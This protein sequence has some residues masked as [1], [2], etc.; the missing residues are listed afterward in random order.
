MR[1]ISIFTWSLCRDF[2][3]R[4]KALEIKQIMANHGVGD[5][6][7]LVSEMGYWSDETIMGSSQ[8]RQA[9]YLVHFMS[10]GCPCIEQPL[11]GQCL[12]QVA[13]N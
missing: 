10:G 6:P 13:L 11:G 1:L 3:I 7:L 8:T 4:E 9:Q 2:P 12:M 5:L